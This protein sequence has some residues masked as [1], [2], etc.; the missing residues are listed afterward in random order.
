MKRLVTILMLAAAIILG[1]MNVEA[2]TTKKKAKARTSQSA[3]KAY[4]SATIDSLLSDYQN[5]CEDINSW[6]PEST[7]SQFGMQST[8]NA[9]KQVYKQLKAA[10]SSMTSQQKSKFKKLVKSIKGK[11]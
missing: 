1:G 8:L 10:E 6:G 11:K 4:S 7:P 9:E 3:K 5:I 2:Q